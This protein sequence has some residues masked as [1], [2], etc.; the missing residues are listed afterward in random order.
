MWSLVFIFRFPLGNNLDHFI[1]WFLFYLFPAQNSHFV[2]L[3]RRTFHLKMERIKMPFNAHHI[4]CR[5][6]WLGIK[7]PS[8]ANKYKAMKSASFIWYILCY[9]HIAF[10]KVVGIFCSVGVLLHSLFSVHNVVT[11]LVKWNFCEWHFD[12]FNIE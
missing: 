12:S 1:K 9:F 6:V 3:L 10:R 2:E 5:I 7:W 4:M 8:S 11:L